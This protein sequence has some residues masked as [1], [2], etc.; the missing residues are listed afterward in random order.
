MAM[1]VLAMIPILCV[2]PF[3]QRFFEKGIIIGSIKG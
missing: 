3:V 2:F 1:N